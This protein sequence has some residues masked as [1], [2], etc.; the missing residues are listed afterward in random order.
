MSNN[1][2]QI[3]LIDDPCFLQ[4]LTIGIISGLAFATHKHININSIRKYNRNAVKELPLPRK[5]PNVQFG[6]AFITASCLSFS[7]CR[8]IKKTKN[9]KLKQTFDKLRRA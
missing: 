3:R 9:E 1:T 7:T 6:V 4:A 5:E 2:K 8:T